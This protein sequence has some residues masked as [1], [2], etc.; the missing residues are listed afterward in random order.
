MAGLAAGVQLGR[1]RSGS[2]AL[3]YAFFLPAF[4]LVASVS[5]LPLLYAVRQSLYKADYLDLGTFVG[6]GNFIRFFT[7]LQGLT[8][9]GQS[10]AFVGG[11]LLLTLPLG[12]ALALL[13]NLKFPLRGVFRVILITPWLV[14]SVVTAMLWA[15]LLNGDFGPFS[16]LLAAFGLDMPTAVTSIT[17]AMPALMVA[18]CWH[19]YPLVMV[20]VLAA[21]QTIPADLQEAALVDGA[22]AWQRFSL[23]T[24]PLIKNTVLVA[25]VLATLNTFNNAA[26]VFVMTGGGPIDVTRTLALSAFLEGFKF[27]HV[28][29]ASAIA[30]ICFAFNALFTLL[31]IRVLQTADDR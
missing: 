30:V 15:W 25:L 7:Q 28:G 4:A 3:A 24:V 17:F 13:L 21:L 12:V 14:S 6:F 29:L 26:L 1:V 11:S 18:N 10:L 23:I 8:V 27:Y 9:V 16:P 2:S 31:Y 22:T 19:L 5:F 20:L